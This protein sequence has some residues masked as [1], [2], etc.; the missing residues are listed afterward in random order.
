[1]SDKYTQIL[2]ALTAPDQTFAFKE[3]I[4]PSGITYS[5]FT[6]IPR[7]LANYFEYG[8]MFPEW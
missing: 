3:E 2:G 1:M 7:T 4:H 6:N 5:E 8:L